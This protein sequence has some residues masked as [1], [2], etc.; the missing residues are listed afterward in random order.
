MHAKF[1]YENLKESVHLSDL[2]GKIKVFKFRTTSY[3]ANCYSKVERGHCP[4][5]GVLSRRE[6]RRGFYGLFKL[7]VFE[8][9]VACAGDETILEPL[10]NRVGISLRLDVRDKLKGLRG[11][12]WFATFKE[13]QRQIERAINEYYISTERILRFQGTT[14]NDIFF[15]KK[16]INIHERSTFEVEKYVEGSQG[17]LLS[18]V[19]GVLSGY[20]E[21]LELWGVVPVL[22]YNKKVKDEE[23]EISIRAPV[24]QYGKAYR[25]WVRVND[26]HFYP[27]EPVLVGGPVRKKEW[28]YRVYHTKGWRENLENILKHFVSLEEQSI[29][30]VQAAKKIDVEQA[31]D[32]LPEDLSA[33]EKEDILRTWQG[34][35]LWDLVEIASNVNK[36]AAVS[37]LRKFGFLKEL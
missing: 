5:C 14:R 25:A 15:M 1:I 20:K 31:K 32:I 11:Q 37:I 27:A 4:K 3:C 10:L 33:E 35:S 7:D 16:L 22:R 36:S 26:V 8:R 17:E 29:K 2:F 23:I 28:V 12:V 24:A 18:T 30:A 21:I 6:I 19:R 13:I 9:D 34:G